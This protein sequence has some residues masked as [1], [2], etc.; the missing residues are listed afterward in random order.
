MTEQLEYEVFLA[1]LPAD[2]RPEI[3][4]VW[5]SVRENMPNG[6]QESIDRKVLTFRAGGEWYA[7]LSNQKNYI[8]LYLMPIYVFPEL[9]T[10]LDESGKKLKG[11]KSCINFSRADDLPLGAIGEIVAATAPAAYLAQIEKIRSR[12]KEAK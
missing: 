2:R 4:R 3:E 6:Y 9:K 12:R 10:K 8:S 1:M 5:Q 7:A 11:G